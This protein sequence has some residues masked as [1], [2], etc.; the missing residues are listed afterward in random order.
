MPRQ[1]VIPKV[2]SDL[3]EYLDQLQERYVGEPE[4]G[5][6]PTLPLTPEGKIN[7]RAVA[8]AIGLKESQEKYLY[9]RPELTQLINLICEGQGVLPIG[10][11]LSQRVADKAI[12]ERLERQARAATDASRDAAEAQGAL[13]DMLERVSGMAA[14]LEVLRAENQRLRAQID[15]MDE[16]IFV[17]IDS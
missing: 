1:S 11:R 16:G 6:R 15:A 3:T 17:R 10:S 4:H 9:E 12:K 7:V 2:L 8:K 13:Q 14:E 5:R